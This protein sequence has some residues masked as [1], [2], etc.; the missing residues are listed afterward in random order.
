MIRRFLR[1]AL[2]LTLLDA[3]PASASQAEPPPPAELASHLPADS[4]LILELTDAPAALRC[5]SDA[6]LH[7]MGMLFLFFYN[8]AQCSS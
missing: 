1:A 3:L 2:L 4:R 8:I 6:P 5:L 7:L